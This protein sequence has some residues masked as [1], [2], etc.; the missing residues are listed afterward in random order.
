MKYIVVLMLS[1][2][3]A[4]CNQE[5]APEADGPDDEFIG[6]DGKTDTGEV[7]EGSSHA[8]GVLALA[9]EATVAVLDDSPP[10]NVGLDSRAANNIV[11]YRLGDD[12][13]PGTEDDEVFDTLREL[14]AVFYVGPMAFRRLLTY[15]TDQGY[16]AACESEMVDQWGFFA[17]GDS[18]SKPHVLEAIARGMVALDPD[19]VVAFNTGDIT[20]H[21]TYEQWTEHLEVLAAGAPDPSVP[22]DPL[23]IVRQ[24]RLRTDVGRFGPWIRYIGV[25]G[26]HDDN[27]GE[28][29]NTWN[30]FLPGQQQLGRN[31]AGGIYFTLTYENA[32]FIVLD[33]NNPSEEQTEWLQGVLESPEAEEAFWI[34]PFFHY[35]VYPCNSKT[36]WGE[37]LEWVDLFEQ[38]DI[39]IAFV[40]HSHTY[41]RTCPMVGGRCEEGGVIYLNSSAAGAPVRSISPD[42]VETVSHDGRTDEFDCAEILAEGRGYWDHFCHINIE[43]CRLTLSCYDHD[44][45]DTGGDPYDTLVIDRCE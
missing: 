28:W 35:P 14:D 39:D 33:S 41:E 30:T 5:S 16:V 34:F 44:W 8:C 38:H 18:R 26:N 11:A 42:R 37:G 4:G 25:I 17:I 22:E 29:F 10:E 20:S 3:I 45:A 43:D 9:N 2:R 13:E 19:A 40:A 23:G 6:P 36:P 7:E 24:S 21:G 12:G 15:A 31:D 27:N 32:L 1:L